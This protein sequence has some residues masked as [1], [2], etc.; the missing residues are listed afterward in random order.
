MVEKK[1][2][3]LCICGQEAFRGEEWCEDCLHKIW[4]Q[5]AIER[6]QWEDEPFLIWL[7]EMYEASKHSNEEDIL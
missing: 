6:N 3:N 7:D 2:K 1:E 5:E 4:I